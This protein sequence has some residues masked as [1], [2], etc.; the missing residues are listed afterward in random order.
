MRCLRLFHAGDTVHRLGPLLEYLE[1][2]DCQVSGG[3]E[4]LVRQLHQ[5]GL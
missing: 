1:H 3:R 4:R 2:S 5:A